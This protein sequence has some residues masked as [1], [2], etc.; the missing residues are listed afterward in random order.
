MRVFLIAVLSMAGACLGQISQ[1]EAAKKM[2]EKRAEREAHRAEVVSVSQGEL[3]DLHDE[4]RRLQAQIGK[5]QASLA[6]EKK[7]EASAAAKEA[8][9]VA[10]EAKAREVPDPIATAIREHTLALGMSLEQANSAMGVAGTKTGESKDGVEYT[11]PVAKSYPPG[12]TVGSGR[13]S[14]SPT[15][16]RRAVFKDGVLSEFHTDE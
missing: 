10:Q 7:K 11:W 2:A 15:R 9:R 14:S 4:I 6:E 13:R 5:L 1:E 8:A 12:M 16:Y 3:D